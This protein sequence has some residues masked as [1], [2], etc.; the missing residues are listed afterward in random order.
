MH[1]L[2]SPEYR[3]NPEIERTFRI[4]RRNQRENIGVGVNL[5]EEGYSS[6]EVM[7]DQV[8]PEAVMAEPDIIGIANDRG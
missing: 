1:R 8:E 2:L 6:E 5:A 3:A 7:D 4:L